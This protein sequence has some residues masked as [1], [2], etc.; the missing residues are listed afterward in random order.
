[1]TALAPSLRG[2]KVELESMNELSQR[3]EF[4]FNIINKLRAFM[5]IVVCLWMRYDYPA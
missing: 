3:V 5:K 1:M 2:A 4:S